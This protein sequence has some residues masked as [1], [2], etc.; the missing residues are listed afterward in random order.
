MTAKIKREELFDWIIVLLL[1]SA[2]VLICN[3][4]GYG[5]GFMESLPGMTWIVLF[6]LAGMIVK[7]LVPI[8]LPDAAYIS[9]IAILF[10]MPISP[11]SDMV[12]EQVNQ[13]NLLAICTPILAYAGVTV[14][15]DWPAFKKIGYKGVI[16]S[17]IVIVG[18]VLSCVILSE[19]FFRIF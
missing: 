12:I 18:T 19:I 4:L 6:T 7:P 15:K 16:V 9:I 8:D 11:V 17:L 14:G 10:S 3:L 5:I 2:M 1:T 13:I